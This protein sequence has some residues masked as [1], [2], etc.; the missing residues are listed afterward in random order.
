MRGSHRLLR[1][2]LA[3]PF[4]LAAQAQTIPVTDPAFVRA[5]LVVTTFDR[6]HADCRRSGGFDDAQ[7]AKLNKW[8]ADNG[9]QG[10]RVRVPALA[11]HASLKQQVDKGADAIVRRM[12]SEKVNPCAAAVSVSK[13]PDAQFAKVAPQLVSDVGPPSTAEKPPASPG[14]EPASVPAPAAK[15]AGETQ[16]LLK[17]IDSFGFDTRPKMGVGGFITLDIYP[18]VLM[19]SGEALTDVRGL[20]APGGLEAHKRANPQ[21]WTRWR[22]EGGKLELQ[23][24]KG[25]EALPFQ[26]TY[27]QLPGD[28]KLEGLYRDLEGAGTVGAGGTQSVTVYDQYRFGPDGSVERTG[29]A[30]SAAEA[31]DASVAT[32]MR[33]APRRGRYTVDGLTLTIRYDDG[34]SEQRILIADPKDPGTA[35]WLDG[36]GYV[37]R[38][39]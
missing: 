4:T 10:I 29:G 28:L 11:E 5:A 7:T 21:D 13:L 1:A 37:K 18:V 8:Q 27:A 12:F 26:T 15:S 34:S 3:L 17:Q 38:G 25:W 20:A 31:G 23:K 2:L 6:L 9:V 32:S 24:K 30:G 33:R 36:A 39:K 14:A 35:I 19:K 22:R 16:A